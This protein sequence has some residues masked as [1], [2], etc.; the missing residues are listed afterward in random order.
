MSDFIKTATEKADQFFTSR[1]ILLF[2]LCSGVIFSLFYLIFCNDMYRD[3]AFC[4]A[5]YAREFGE[6]SWN[7]KAI[8][9]LPPPCSTSIDRFKNTRDTRPSA[10][11]SAGIPNNKSSRS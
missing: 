11:R 4:Y 1:R 10:S 7:G 9:Q 3:V 2:A 5:R 6:G 8:F